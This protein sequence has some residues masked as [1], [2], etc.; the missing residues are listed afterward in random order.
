MPEALYTMRR[1]AQRRSRTSKLHQC[2]VAIVMAQSCSLSNG[3]DRAAYT[4]SLAMCCGLVYGV[5]PGEWD[6][7]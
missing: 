7:L 4:C 5:W 6:A 3:I 2:S 1:E